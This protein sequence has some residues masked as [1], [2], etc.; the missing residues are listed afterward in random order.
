MTPTHRLTQS[1]DYRESN[2]T[3]LPKSALG[4]RTGRVRMLESEI[5]RLTERIEYLEREKAQVE[6]FAAVAA[7]ELAEPLVMA[8]AYTSIVSERLG[9]PE[10]DCSREDLH[11]LGRSMA[12][13]RM[14]V[15][16][17][18]HEAKSGAHAIERRPVRVNPLVANCIALLQP[19]VAAREVQITV[20]KLPDVSADEALLGGVFGNLLINALKYSPRHGAQISVGGAA[21]NG[22]CQYWVDSE[23][24]TIPVEDRE[25]IFTSFQRGRGRA[26]RARRRARVEHLPPDRHPARRRD[27]RH[28]RRR[29]R[30]P[31]LLHV[32]QLTPARHWSWRSSAAGAIASLRELTPSL[33]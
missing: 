11:T 28:A 5:E 29:R 16:S 8:E 25:R 26:T 1:H 18:L 22:R 14:L 7:H 3:G 23:G 17:V 13:L 21:E 32:A 9:G 30:Q 2:G 33:R 4:G 24:P 27:R 20:A 6:A 12:R 19:E 10:H 15:E 31:L